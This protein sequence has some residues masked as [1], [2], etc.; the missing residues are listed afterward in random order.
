MNSEG[1]QWARENADAPGHTSSGE[2]AL[3]ARARERIEREAVDER[4]DAILWRVT[5]WGA[6]AT[7]ALTV[8]AWLTLAA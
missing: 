8:A 4:A 1:R 2:E 6:A 7:V 5:L 3:E